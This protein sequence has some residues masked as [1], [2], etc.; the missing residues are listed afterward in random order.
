MKKGCAI[1]IGLS[2]RFCVFT[3]IAAP[4]LLL[5]ISHYHPQE[6]AYDTLIQKVWSLDDSHRLTTALASAGALGGHL[7]WGLRRRFQG[8]L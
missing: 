3:F 4:M 6:A 2:H 8:G 7:R 1:L 5:A